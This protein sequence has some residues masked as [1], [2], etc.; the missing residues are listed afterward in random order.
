MCPTPLAELVTR[1]ASVHTKKPVLTASPM[2]QPKTG[3]LQEYKPLSRRHVNTRGHWGTTACFPWNQHPEL[4]F[5][6]KEKLENL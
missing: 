1:H 3:K 6:R 5:L 2:T 4:A